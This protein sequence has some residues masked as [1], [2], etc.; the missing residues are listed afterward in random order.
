[1]TGLIFELYAHL[2]LNWLTYK[3]KDTTGITK[4]VIYLDQ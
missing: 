1:M 4:E 3:K 2:N